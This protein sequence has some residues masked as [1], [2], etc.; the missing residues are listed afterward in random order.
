MN[1]LTNKPNSATYLTD[2]GLET[3]LLFN[4]GIDL[5]HFAAFPL[6]EDPIHLETLKNYYREYLDLSAKNGFGFILESP[7]WR[8]NTDWAYKLGYSDEELKAVNKKSIDHLRSLRMEYEAFLPEILISGQIGPRGD[9]YSVGSTMTREEARE[10]HQLQI[11]TF[12]DSG[13]DLTLSLIHI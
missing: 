1:S 6:V 12:K 9:G 4:K 11:K 3:E 5:P 10:Y 13:A 8:A 7:T 2:G